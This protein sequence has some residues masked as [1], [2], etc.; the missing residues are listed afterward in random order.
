MRLLWRH[1][2]AAVSVNQLGRTRFIGLTRDD[3]AG[4]NLFS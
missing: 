2:G 4:D 3:R 1:A